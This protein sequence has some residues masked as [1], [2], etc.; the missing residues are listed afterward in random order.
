MMFH[1]KIRDILH[2]LS[3]IYPLNK[4]KINTLAKVKER[5]KE[6]AFVQKEKQEKQ[7]NRVTNPVFS[8]PVKKAKL[9]GPPGKSYI[10]LTICWC[11]YFERFGL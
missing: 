9:H 8:L 6:A 10:V 1:M 7:V 3:Y 4:Y 2:N 5:K 11:L